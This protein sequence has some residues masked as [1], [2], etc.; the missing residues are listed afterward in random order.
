MIQVKTGT[1]QWEAYNG[2]L[3]SGFVLFSGTFTY[4]ADGFTPLMVWDAAAG[5]VRA[6]TSAEIAALPAQQQAARDAAEPDLSAM[7]DSATA[8]F[9]ANATYIALASPSTAQNT[10]QIK[11]LSQQMQK[12][13]KALAR[14]SIKAL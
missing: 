6:M 9:N 10:A 5:N 3:K 2:T 4:A 1:T 12:V 13:I 7:R 14:L 8:A 11:A